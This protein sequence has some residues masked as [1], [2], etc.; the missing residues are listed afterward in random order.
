MILNKKVPTVI[1]EIVID[2]YEIQSIVIFSDNAEKTP[3]VKVT[4][5]PFSTDTSV[6]YPK[7][8]KTILLENPDAQN[9]VISFIELIKKYL[10]V[11]EL[12]DE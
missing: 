12:S 9:S 4:L 5:I 3:S 11:V 10:E 7:D 8:S 1:P 6:R 2:Q